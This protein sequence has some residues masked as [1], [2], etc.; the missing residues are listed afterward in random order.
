MTVLE[1]KQRIENELKAVAESFGAASSLVQYSVEVDVN[2]IEGADEDITAIFGSLSI[3]PEGTEGNDRLYLPLDAEL[4]DDDT[5]DE[6][7]FEESLALFKERVADIREKML[8]SDDY[9]AA[10]AAI[11]EDFDREMDEKYRAELERL[12]NIAK[13]NLIIAAAATAAAAVIALIVLVATKL[14]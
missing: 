11:I 1:T 3:G 14:A 8:A 2:H 5:V 6:A 9:N 12:N 10:A 13:R 7:A 4:D